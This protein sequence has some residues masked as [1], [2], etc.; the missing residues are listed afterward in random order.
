VFRLSD[1]LSRRIAVNDAGAT[2]VS[3]EF[4]MEVS[5][6]KRRTNSFQLRHR[7]WFRRIWR[8]KRWKSKKAPDQQLQRQLQLQL[9]N[10]H[11]QQGAINSS[12]SE[13]QHTLQEVID[14]KQAMV[15]LILF[16]IDLVLA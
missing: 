1:Q 15:K 13:S 3:A 5:S 7:P 6:K 11:Q 16:K 10:L 9:L 2:Q 8:C 12:L 4:D 14:H